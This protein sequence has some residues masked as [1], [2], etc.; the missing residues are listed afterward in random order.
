M[1]N[2]N[3]AMQNEEFRIN[4][5][6]TNYAAL[7][8]GSLVVR[9]NKRLYKGCYDFGTQGGAIGTI[10]LFDPVYSKTQALVLPANFIVMQCIIDV[11]TAPTSGG[12]ATLALT[13]GQGAGDLLT[14][15]AK[16]SFTG[17]LAGVPVGTAATAI[18]IPA[19]QANPG[20]TVSVVIATAALTAG[21][22][23]VFL[24]GY[25]SDQL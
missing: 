2:Q 12:S 1:I 21:K 16:A 19:A 5:G 13:S 20:S 25:L 9:R 7:K 22:F 11:I 18:K 23:N 8:M 4:H 6:D 24:E 17:I 15:T 14:A 3:Q 10:A